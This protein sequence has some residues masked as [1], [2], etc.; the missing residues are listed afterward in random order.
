ME[1]LMKK[2]LKKHKNRDESD[3][4]EEGESTALVQALREQ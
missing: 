2:R 4:E 3:S 1:A